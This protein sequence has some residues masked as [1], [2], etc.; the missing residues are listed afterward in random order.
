MGCTMHQPSIGAGAIV[1]NN[2]N[3]FHEENKIY[4]YL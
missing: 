3:S 1:G 4:I 2:T